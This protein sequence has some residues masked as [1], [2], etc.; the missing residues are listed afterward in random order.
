[1]KITFPGKKM[2]SMVVRFHDALGP[3]TVIAENV[4]ALNLLR[5]KIVVS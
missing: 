1:M 2:K 3:S 4:G 5:Y